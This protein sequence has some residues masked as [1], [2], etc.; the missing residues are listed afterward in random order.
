MGVGYSVQCDREVLMLEMPKFYGYL[1][2]QIVDISSFL[3]MGNVWLPHKMRT[4]QRKDSKY[5]H[6]AMND[7]EDSI[8]TLKWVRN[9]LFQSSWQVE[10][11]YEEL[12]GDK[13]NSK[14]FTAAV[15][16][17]PEDLRPQ[18]LR[19]CNALLAWAG[20]T[21]AAGRAPMARRQRCSWWPRCSWWSLGALLVSIVFIK[22]KH[23]GL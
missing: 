1:S 16:P 3:R 6:R 21:P 10:S 2:H 11:H 22:R 13:T 4:R 19:V 23:Y 17:P 8:D 12:D 18:F 14:H 20:I 5:N 15:L 7:I 9:N